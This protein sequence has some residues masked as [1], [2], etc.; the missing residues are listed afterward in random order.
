MDAPLRSHCQEGRLLVVEHRLEE[1]LLDLLMVVKLAHSIKEETAAHMAP[2]EVVAIMEE[3][4]AEMATIHFL[5]LEEDPAMSV[6][7]QTLALPRC[8]RAPL[9][10]APV[11]WRRL[12]PH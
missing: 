10:S 1:E 8:S 9:A 3:E 6:A 4:A 7:V 2:E 11:Q 5:V 12:K